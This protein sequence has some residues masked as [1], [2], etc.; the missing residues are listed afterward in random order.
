VTN[1]RNTSSPHWRMWL[2]LSAACVLFELI[3]AGHA[4]DLIGRASII[5]DDTLEF[6]GTRIWLGHQ[7]LAPE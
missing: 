5:D 7:A 4:A 6:H 1:I 3:N 2:S